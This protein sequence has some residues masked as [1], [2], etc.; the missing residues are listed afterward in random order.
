MARLCALVCLVVLFPAQVLTQQITTHVVL[1]SIDGMRPE[2]Y[3]D[4]QWP[5]PNLQAIK[6]RGLYARQM[7]SV[8]PSYTYPSHVA[9]LTGALPARSGIAYNAPIGSTGNWNWFTKA[10]K[11]PTLWQAI[12]AAGMTSSAV[13]WPVSVGPEITYDIPEI[14]DP[15]NG[16]DRITEA[17]NYA[18]PGLID[19]IERNATGKLDG[20]N[21]NEEYLGLDENA[22]RMAAYIFTTYKPNFL[23]VHFALVDGA[24]HEQGREGPKV[25]VAIATADH[26]IGDILESIHRSGLEDSTTVIVVGDHGFMDIHTVL[27]PNVWLKQRGI[28]AHF[29]PAGGSA[30]LYLQTPGDVKTLEQVRTVLRGLPFS[31]RKLLTVYDRAKLDEMGADSG[32]ALALAAVPGIVFGGSADG[33]V[34]TGAS[35]GHHGY[36]P[37]LPEMATGFLAQGRGI[38]PGAVIPQLTVTDIAPLIARLLGLTFQAPDGVLLPG[39]LKQ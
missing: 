11:V 28:R 12:K 34:L 19:E 36:D 6:A 1:I 13:E 9:M 35:G 27:R 32:A 2:F 3:L 18:T 8:F 14:W 20:Q 4:A 21:M 33:A 5:T 26:A 10:I 37:D 29:E 38:R 7:R 22:G 15:K 31:Q 23:A 17:R 25:R 24:E 16:E 39:I 30:F